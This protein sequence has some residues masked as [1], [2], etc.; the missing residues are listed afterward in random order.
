[1]NDKIASGASH[2]LP[3]E[4]GKDGAFAIPED[5]WVQLSPIGEFP[6][7]IFGR[8]EHVR[9]IQVVDDQAVKAMVADQPGENAPRLFDFEHR[10]LGDFSS[11]TSA[12]GWI[13]KLEARP[14]GLWGH[15][16]W[17]AK[18]LADLR[19]GNYRF[20]SPVFAAFDDLG[21]G[22][23]RP[24]KLHSAGLTNKPNIQN[25]SPVANSASAG[26]PKNTMDYKAELLKLCGLPAEATD[27]QIAA[28]CTETAA[29]CA[30]GKKA[31]APNK[32][33]EDEVASLRTQL[34]ANKA[35]SAAALLAAKGIKPEHPAYGALKE[36]LVANRATGETL[37]A[38]VV[39]SPA[40]ADIVAN[41]QPAKQ[42]VGFPS[43]PDAEEVAANKADSAVRT[44]MAAN[45][46]PFSTAWDAVRRAQPELFAAPA[47]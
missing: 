30:K 19:G 23:R 10:S 36:A 3:F 47:K 43:Q 32:T 18:G 5:G 25:L 45:K 35:E 17:S 29:N 8:D 42:P 2:P 44:Y 31:V 38:A 14:D 26:N 24:A 34:A 1:M 15:V 21:D 39:T 16:R 13:D 12:A 4:R 33:L 6:G 20:L 37:L 41:R 28:A 46:V 11:D 9:F 27:E 22:R 7:E 40:A